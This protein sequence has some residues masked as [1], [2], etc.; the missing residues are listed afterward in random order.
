MP[1]GR[2]PAIRFERVRRSRSMR[3]RSASYRQR[4]VELV[5]PAVDADLVAFGSDAALLVGV[6][7]GGDGRDV[8]RRRDRRTG[9]AASGCSGTPTRLPY[10]PQREP[11]DRL[12]RR[13]AA[14]SCRGQ[15]RTT[16]RR[17]TA[18]RPATARAGGCGRHAAWP[19]SVRHCASGHCQGSTGGGA[20]GVSSTLGGPRRSLRP[21]AAGLD[22]RQGAR[23]ARRVR[24]AGTMR[25]RRDDR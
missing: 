9:R 8:E 10:C 2:T 23:R 13:R 16:A 5:D 22:R 20:S 25:S 17:R 4:R 6:E 21:T 1:T 18:R 14:R 19:T 15:S 7:E 11:A 12:D 24:R 3:S